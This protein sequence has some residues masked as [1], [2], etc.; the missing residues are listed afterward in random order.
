MRS[1]RNRPSARPRGHTEARE[2]GTGVLSAQRRGTLPPPGLSHGPR[3]AAELR[4]ARQPR[5]GQRN[6]SR[7]PSELRLGAPPRRGPDEVCS[8]APRPGE[9]RGRR[10]PGGQRR[11]GTHL[12]RT[13]LAGGRGSSYRNSRRSSRVAGP[14][15]CPPAE[16]LPVPAARAC[17]R[18]GGGAGP[19]SCCTAPGAA[20][21]GPGAR[22]WLSAGASPGATGTWPPPSSRRGG[23]GAAA[24]P[25][26]PNS[27]PRLPPRVPEGP[28]W[29][30]R[31][32]PLTGTGRQRLECAARSEPGNLLG[33]WGSGGALLTA[34]AARVTPPRCTQAFAQLS[35]GGGRWG[36]ASSS[37][38]G[39]PLPGRPLSGLQGPGGASTRGGRRRTASHSF[40][41]SCTSG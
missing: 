13:P 4:V 11:E 24:G 31:P 3:A 12:Q 23:P 22:S 35:G 41:N 5:R 25:P 33:V 26:P 2:V 36:R 16:G 20:A 30:C 32:S 39:E 40:G 8:P 29:S 1:W 7:R 34:G 38:T 10:P 28:E 15:P 17:G 18:P 14:W 21:S 9:E 37:Q 27:A 6:N 19:G